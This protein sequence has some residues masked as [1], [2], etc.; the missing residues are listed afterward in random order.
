G[1]SAGGG[2]VQ[3]SITTPLDREAQETQSFWSDLRNPLV[4]EGEVDR[5]VREGSPEHFAIEGRA[6]VIRLQGQSLSIFEVDGELV[7]VYG[8][9]L[10]TANALGMVLWNEVLGSAALIMLF[11]LVGVTRIARGRP[12]RKR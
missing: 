8:A 6:S 9:R 2:T 4:A 11:A 10:D 12:A 3:P 5:F 1:P 7:G